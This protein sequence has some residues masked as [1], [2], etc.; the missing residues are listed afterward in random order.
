MIFIE[1]FYTISSFVNG[2][3]N[4]WKWRLELLNIQFTNK[5]NIIF[6]SSLIKLI[7]LENIHHNDFSKPLLK[8]LDCHFE[9]SIACLRLFYIQSSL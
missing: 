1:N 8:L 6:M 2:I 5:L 4:S 3:I 7:N 9:A